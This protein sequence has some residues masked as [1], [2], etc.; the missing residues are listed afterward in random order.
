MTS[1]PR[2]DFSMNPSIR[3]Q[4]EK[5]RGSVFDRLGERLNAK[6]TMSQP[7]HYPMRSKYEADV[8][9]KL[10]SVQHSSHSNRHNY[11]YHD[12]QYAQESN[13]HHVQPDDNYRVNPHVPSRSHMIKSKINKEE[14]HES[15]QYK[16]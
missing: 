15:N 13:Q 6:P 7:P 8:R 12:N 2:S 11:N 9:R 4:Q 16:K 5:A 1:K 3:D 10:D 14:Y